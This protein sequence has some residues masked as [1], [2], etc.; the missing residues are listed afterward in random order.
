MLWPN[1]FILS[2]IISS[3]S[4]GTPQE[5]TGHLM[6]REAHLLVSYFCLLFYT[7]HKVLMAKTL[8]WVAIPSSSGS[9]F[10]TTLCV[11]YPTWVAIHGMAHS[12]IELHKTLA[13]K[14]GS[15]L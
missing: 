14:Q 1:H 11:T 3:L 9:S 12:F 10:V 2:G 6:T 15:D 13:S 5:H 8:E 4:S 7:V